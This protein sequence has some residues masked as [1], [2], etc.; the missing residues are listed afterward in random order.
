ML[1]LYNKYVAEIK[2]VYITNLK[3]ETGGFMIYLQ[4]IASIV[5]PLFFLYYVISSIVEIKSKLNMII[6]HFDM[7]EEV[8]RVIPNEEIEKELE[9]LNK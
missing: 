5:I 8:D 7:K 1:P 3:C 9:E 4:I 2:L 6:E